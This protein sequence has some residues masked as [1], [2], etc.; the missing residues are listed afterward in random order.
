MYINTCIVFIVFED[1]SQS[2]QNAFAARR[3]EFAHKSERR[4]ADAK[5]RAKKLSEKR[6]EE[7]GQTIASWKKA[8]GLSVKSG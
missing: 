8:R 4:L 1:S 3:P 2:L 6:V 7:L 5:E